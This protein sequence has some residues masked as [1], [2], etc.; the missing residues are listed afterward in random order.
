MSTYEG[1]YQAPL[2]RVLAVALLFA[3]TLFLTPVLP[4]VDLP[5]HA[6]QV[7]WLNRWLHN[8]ASLPADLSVQLVSPYLLA[9]LVALLIAQVTSVLVAVKLTV[10]I[11]VVAIPA[12]VFWY[13]RV[14]QADPQNAILTTPLAF[15]YIFACG[16]L[17][18]F[19]AVPCT[20]LFLAAAER[21][22]ERQTYSSGLFVL[23]T[24]LLVLLAH[25][26]AAAFS[27]VVYAVNAALR[28]RA[29][30]FAK[31]VWPVSFLVI[32]LAV[33]AF[34]NS[35]ASQETGTPFSLGWAF[36]TR[37]RHLPYLLVGAENNPTSIAGGLAVLGIA[38]YGLARRVMA[39]RRIDGV[40]V[41]AGIA[42]VIY[43]VG[44]D[45]AFGTAVIYQRFAIWF[46]LFAI[47]G[48]EFGNGITRKILVAGVLLWVFVVGTRM[49]AFAE[50]SH[51]F[52]AV[53]KSVPPH[54]TVAALVYDREFPGQGDVFLHFPAYYEVLSAG[55]V[56]YE[57]TRNFA[58]PVRTTAPPL[59]SD[60]EYSTPD[61]FPREKIL[62]YQY[63][64]TKR[65]T[66]RVAQVRSAIPK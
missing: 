49:R 46:A 29:V 58:V 18:F 10:A 14:S 17:N 16:F 23:L 28:Y 42:G 30:S 3:M 60:V 9:Y 55:R 38:L 24:S 6:A 62:R 59:V 34:T 15:G 21:H 31:V 52:L 48:G 44:P 45:Q 8:P 66:W 63:L 40:V 1:P 37:L 56:S 26:I 51:D 54:K 65:G 4:M 7:A 33:W 43:I 57:F 25:P 11:I 20:V 22:F 53:I 39:G 12:S 47:A 5:Q 32:A 61:A 35:S 27:L 19:V 13:A 2:L 64:L 41:A 36:R 50:P